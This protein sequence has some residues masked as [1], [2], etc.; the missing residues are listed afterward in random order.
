M[1]ND[2]PSINRFEDRGY[3]LE[4]TFDGEEEPTVLFVADRDFDS[5]KSLA[6]D[7]Q[8]NWMEL[9]DEIFELLEHSGH[10]NEHQLGKDLTNRL[11]ET[12]IDFEPESTSSE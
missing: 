9:R 7:N 12:L 10:E 6:E 4:L 3:F 11:R 2:T 8:E 5:L 1:P